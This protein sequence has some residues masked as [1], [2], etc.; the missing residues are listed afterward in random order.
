METAILE[1][2]CNDVGRIYGSRTGGSLDRHPCCCGNHGG[3]GRRSYHCDQRTDAGTANAE[4]QCAVGSV[5]ASAALL[6]EPPGGHVGSRG[7]KGGDHDTR[8][9]AW[10]H[11]DGTR[12]DAYADRKS[13]RLNSSHLGISYAV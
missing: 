3:T 9:A 2:I 7:A 8:I 11:E 4:R 6:P 5:R 1:A 12:A 13:T 10:L